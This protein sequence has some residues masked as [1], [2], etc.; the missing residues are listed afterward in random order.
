MDDDGEPML[1]YIR[2]D[3][4]DDDDARNDTSDAW[5]NVSDD[6]TATIMIRDCMC[7]SDV[8]HGVVFEEI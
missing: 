6:V 8:S 2:R 5:S 7:G 3:V 1:Y 4:R